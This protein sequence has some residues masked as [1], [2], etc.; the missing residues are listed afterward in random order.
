M[1][2]HNVGHCDWLIADGANNTNTIYYHLR[3]REHLRLGA[4][5]YLHIGYFHS[6][7]FPSVFPLSFKAE[8]RRINK[9]N[10]KKCH[11]PNQPASS[12]PNSP[13]H[14]P[15]NRPLRRDKHNLKH[16]H[17]LQHTPHHHSHSSPPSAPASPPSL[18]LSAAPSAPSASSRPSSPSA[19]SSPNTSARSCGC[20]GPR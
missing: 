18:L 5:L 8:D 6:P 15:K 9:D 7:S 11:P 20:A 10:R 1:P 14:V 4:L 12:R 13:N 3:I 2:V 19:S 16:K 17:K